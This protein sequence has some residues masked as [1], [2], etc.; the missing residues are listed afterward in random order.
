MEACRGEIRFAKTQDR[1]IIGS[2]N[3]FIKSH[4]F[5]YS[6]RG[7]SS[8]DSDRLNRDMPTRGFPD[9]SKDYKMSLQVLAD[10]VRK[11]F[12]LEFVPQ[13]EDFRKQVISGELNTKEIP[14]FTPSRAFVFEVCLSLRDM[15]GSREDII[16]DIVVHGNESLFHLAEAILSSYDFDCDHCFGFYSDLK[17]K[18]GVVPGEVYELFVDCH[19]VEPTCDHALSVE[20]TK[21]GEA[22]PDL[23]KQMRFLFDYGDN[24]E[25]VVTLNEFRPINPKEKLPCVTRS[26]GEAPEQYPP[27][28]EDIDEE[29]EQNVDSDLNIND[30]TAE[31]AVSRIFESMPALGVA[32][33]KYGINPKFMIR[34]QPI[35]KLCQKTREAK[36]LTIKQVAMQLNVPQYRLK[37]IEAASVEKIV[38]DVLEKYVDLLGLKDFFSG[39]AEKNKDIHQH[40]KSGKRK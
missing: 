1:R 7:W 35:S 17:R 32:M 27:C 30:E 13:T 9:G 23:G 33:E 16:R 14:G 20:K 36:N 38:F 21:I 34:F 3:E 25:F 12:G 18:R 10:V 29:G 28:E 22:F 5:S 31:A 26:V 24:W 2:M 40:I 4:K 8:Q 11:K 19:D 6:F 37:D 15:D 39:W